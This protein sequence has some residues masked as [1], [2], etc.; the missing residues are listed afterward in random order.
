MMKKLL[1]MLLAAM[2]LLGCV[3]FAE[4][5]DYVGEW[6]LTGAEMD[7]LPLE[8]TIQDS[9]VLY[10][11]GTCTMTRMGQKVT[12]KAS[13][14]GVVLTD[15]IGD[16]LSYVLV[17]GKLV[18]ELDGMKYTYSRAAGA[19]D[20]AG[21][22][23]LTGAEMAGTP[24]DLSLI[25]LEMTMD[26]RADGTCTLTTMGE[27]EEGVWT[28]DA[29]GAVVTDSYGDAQ[30]LVMVD[31]KL[32]ATQDGMK[33]IFSRTGDAAFFVGKW[34]MTGMVANG[35]E[36]GVETMSMF[37][38]TLTL[39]LNEDGTCVVD[40]MGQKESG[41]WAVTPAGVAITD[42]TETLEFVY[43]DEMLVTEESGSQMMLTREGAA[44]AIV[45]KAAAAPVMN[46]PAEAFEGA[47]ELAAANVF[48][49]DI[50]AAD[51]GV[52]I[53]FDLAA[54][55]GIYQEGD[56]TS[57]YELPIAYTVTD[58]EGEPTLLSLLYQDE[59]LTEPEVLLQLNMLEDGRLQCV[60]LMDG[61]EIFYYFTAVVEEIPAE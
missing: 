3:A 46:V 61:M 10:E 36:M 35:V 7:G 45:E 52:T 17:D 60:I 18:S 21:M 1:C 53:C 54:G 59:T 11:D 14:D 20:Y 42:P 49:M 22:W 47:W 34:V 44:P 48:G 19:V 37:N 27:A 57:L 28:A 15:E 13:S 2:M 50:T 23:T 38:L 6:I 39:T 55:A 4:A 31:G 25:G 33:I 56:G 12:W 30:I 8:V 26:L 51:M 16:S 32:E 24:I 5:V 58:P 9:L 29:S 40:G 43:V 41:T